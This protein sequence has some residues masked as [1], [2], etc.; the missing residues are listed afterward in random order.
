[1]W[2]TLFGLTDLPSFNSSGAK[3]IRFGLT[4]LLEPALVTS[5]RL[6]TNPGHE[7]CS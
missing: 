5:L 3:T 2:A 4:D 1:M 6:V 7:P